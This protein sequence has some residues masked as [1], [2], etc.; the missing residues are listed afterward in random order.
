M[1]LELRLRVKMS[2]EWQAYITFAPVPGTRPAINGG[3]K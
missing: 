1:S 3:P 2:E